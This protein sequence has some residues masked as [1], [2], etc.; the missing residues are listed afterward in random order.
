ME[1]I[2]SNGNVPFVD[3]HHLLLKLVSAESED[4]LPQHH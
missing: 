3:K 1:F 2:F 4:T